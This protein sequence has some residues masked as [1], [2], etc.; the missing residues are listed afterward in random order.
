[1]IKSERAKELFLKALAEDNSI[2][3]EMMHMSTESEVEEKLDAVAQLY[4]SSNRLYQ[5]DKVQ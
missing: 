4:I 5:E 1:M 3:E 2:T